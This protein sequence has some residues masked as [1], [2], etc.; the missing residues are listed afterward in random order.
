[1]DME[2]QMKLLFLLLQ[3][4]HLAVFLWS[5]VNLQ[6]KLFSFLQCD[7]FSGPPLPLLHLE[8]HTGWKNWKNALVLISPSSDGRTGIPRL[9]ASS[10][11]CSAACSPPVSWT[12]CLSPPFHL[13]YFSSPWETWERPSPPP[14]RHHH[15]Y[16]RSLHQYHHFPH[17]VPHNLFHHHAHTLTL[18]SKLILKLTSALVPLNLCTT[19]LGTNE[20]PFVSWRGSAPRILS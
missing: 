3:P 6:N 8:C 7:I 4:Q 18:G 5:I 12:V 20:L 16:L 17:Q 11:P 2:E 10:H 13:P 19:F 15:C 14:T 9:Q 1:M